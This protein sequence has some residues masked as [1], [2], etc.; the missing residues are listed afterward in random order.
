[1][2]RNIMMS[3]YRPIQLQEWG[4]RID[5][6]FFQSQETLNKVQA[7]GVDKDG[8][9]GE[10]FFRN[11]ESADFKVVCNL[12]AF[13]VGFENFPMD[14]FGVYS[15]HLKTMAEKPE[16]PML[17]M[18]DSSD[19]RKVF[20]WLKGKV[21]AISGLDDRSAYGLPDK[22][23]V[24]IISIDFKG[25]LNNGKIQSGDFIRSINDVPIKNINDLFTTTDK[26]KWKN[27]LK[28]RL[29]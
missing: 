26:E 6:K 14:R 1:M 7:F 9:S 28:V 21:R 3:A 24:V 18:N 11:P 8:M 25:I 17:I 10:L 2:Q 12:D 22:E 15:E 4:M 27:K 20:E 19:A 13:Q 29:F 23:G 5:Y 16:I